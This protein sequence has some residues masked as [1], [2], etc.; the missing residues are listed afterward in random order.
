ML[1]RRLPVLVRASLLATCGV[2]LSLRKAAPCSAASLALSSPT[3]AGLPVSLTLAARIAS[4]ASR[5]AVAWAES[6]E[7]IAC[8]EPGKIPVHI[9]QNRPDHRPH[10]P[11]RMPL[12]NPLLW[13]H[14]R[15]HPTLIR[16]LSAHRR[17]HRWK[18]SIR[19]SRKL[20]SVFQ[21][22]V[23]GISSEVEPLHGS[24]TP[25]NQQSGPRF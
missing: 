18:Q 7:A 10:R 19:P 11:K 13:R 17:L 23:R 16:K 6:R 12:G 22:T 25:E 9:L 5:S 2:T 8:T 24:E 20:L 1:V 15:K 21:Q 4:D 14:I 3:V